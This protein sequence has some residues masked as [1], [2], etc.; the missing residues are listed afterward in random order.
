MII[1]KDV[2]YWEVM[3]ELMDGNEI[4]VIDKENVKVENLSAIPT[5]ALCNV[6]KKV[7]ADEGTKRNRYAFFKRVDSDTTEDEKESTS[8]VRPELSGGED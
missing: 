6:L 7:K 5:Y 2:Y 3:D 4:F 1:C 8:E